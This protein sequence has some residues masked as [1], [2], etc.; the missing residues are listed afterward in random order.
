MFEHWF[1]RINGLGKHLL[2]AV[3]WLLHF[4]FFNCSLSF[5]NRAFNDVVAMKM[6]ARFFRSPFFPLLPSRDVTLRHSLLPQ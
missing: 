3:P 6:L 2:F 1:A 4:F 5:K